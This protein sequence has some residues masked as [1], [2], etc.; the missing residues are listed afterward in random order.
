M[1][2]Y[3]QDQDFDGMAP[4]NKE[5]VKPS[6][7]AT[8]ATPLRTASVHVRGI[9]VN[10]VSN[11]FLA[12]VNNRVAAGSMTV[13]LPGGVVSPGD[14]ELTVLTKALRDELG[15]T[16]QLQPSNCRFVLSRTYSFEPHPDGSENTAR[17][18]FFTIDDGALVPRNMQPD[19]VLS[20]TWMSLLDLHRYIE[21]D[22]DGWKIQL[23]ALDAI[24]SALE[25]AKAKVVEGRTREIARQD[26]GKSPDGDGYSKPAPLPYN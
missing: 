2:D 26:G 8:T 21:L 1:Y 9:I 4:A 12:L 7:P 11:Q 22:H 6:G 14:D 17:L 10:P 15:L 16:V 19:S 18:D 20:V 23:G 25:P 13:M 24:E 3:D 5:L